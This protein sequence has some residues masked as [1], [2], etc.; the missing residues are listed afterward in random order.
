MR[1]AADLRLS[2]RQLVRSPGLSVT[3]ILSIA[4]GIGAATAIFSV[5]HGVVIDPFPYRDVDSLMSVAIQ[6]PNQRGFRTGY[7]VDQFL[8]IQQ[9]TSIF[10]AVTV[11]T[12]SNVL[13]TGAGD[14]QQ[15]RGNHTTFNGLELMGVPPAAG[16]VF[17]PADGADNAESVCV[18]GFPFWQRQ[19]GGDPSVLGRTLTLNGKART[20]VGIMPPRFMWR[21]ADVYLPVHFRHGETPEGVRYVHLLG[22][23]KPGVTAAQ[24]EADLK[25]VI[26]DLKRLAPESFPEQYRV[27]LRSFAETFPS[28]IRQE[29]W[30]LLA[31][32]ALL[33]L[34]ACANVSSLLLARGLARRGEMAVRMSVGASRRRLVAQLLTESAVLALCGCLLG[35]LLAWGGM[36]AILTVVPPFTIPDESEVRIHLPVLG[37][38]LAL[39][40][41][42]ALLFG[43]GPALASSKTSL[44]EALRSGGRGAVAGRGHGLARGALVVLEVA[45][46]VVLLTSAGLMVRTLMAAESADLGV[47]TDRLLTLRVPLSETRYRENWQR[48]A[49]IENLLAR[50]QGAPGVASAAAN[51]WFHPLGNFSVPVQVPA[52]PLPDS[53]RVNINPVSNGYLGVFAIALKNGRGFTQADVDQRRHVALVSERFV[54]RFFENGSALGQVLSIPALKQPPVSLADDRME[55]VGVVAD[56]A[57]GGLEDQRPELYIP[58][59]LAGVSDCLTVLSA[60]A[61]PFSALPAVRAAVHSIDSDQPI[62]DIRTLEQRIGQQLLSSRRFNAILFGVFACLGLALAAVGIYGVMANSVSRRT[63]EIGVRMAMG[64]AQGDIYRLVLGEGARLLFD[65]VALGSLAAIASSR[66]L[67][68]L[69]WRA[70][71]FDPLTI[72]AVALLLATVGA[73]AC[74]LPA[75]RGARIHPI[76]ALRFD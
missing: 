50:L 5:I 75:R 15:L 40:F 26:D 1:L 19:F 67:A 73:A 41:L 3:A 8:E 35:V 28:G 33:L 55:I 48:S 66:L 58:H 56:T 45:L 63:N 16:R 12:I 39:T 10:S 17:T 25:P 61:D 53:P 76:S 64:A 49:F 36:K 70:R 74:W 44:S 21:G 6:A 54:H 47:R 7:T 57:G 18:L 31:A 32:V 37:F 65:G 23:L 30:L 24:A 71:V 68:Q 59:T 13:W 60:A 4:L 11:S 51:S 43:L 9:R 69:V 52:H 34:I 2:F 72:G 14:P 27:A 29:L 20:V 22:R 38:S 46:S 42:T 62:S